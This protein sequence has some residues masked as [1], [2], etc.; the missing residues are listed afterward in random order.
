MAGLAVAPIPMTV[1]ELNGLAQ[2][3]AVEAFL[4]CCGSSAWAA[5]MADRRPYADLAEMLA[6]ADEVWSGLGPED[7]LEAFAH[8]PRI[9]G[10]D[11]A[12]QRFQTTRAWSAGE[13]SGAAGA[14]DE[15]RS[16]LAA[17]NDE[18][19]ERFGFVFLICATGR[20]AAEML[21]SLQSRIGN[22]RDTELRI[23]AE[24]Q[25]RI[26]RLRIEKLVTP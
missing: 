20:S 13:Q 14:S 2:G 6:R 25:R 15:L 19:F 5:E 23:A 9:G 1:D 18:Y 16:R 4:R 7:W 24:E 22:D 3:D 11:S 10:D 26:L 12:Q 21:A 8:H 17:G